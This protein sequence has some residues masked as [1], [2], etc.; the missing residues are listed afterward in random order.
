M[1]IPHNRK[2]QYAAQRACGSCETIGH[3][4]CGGKHRHG[5]H[6]RNT[7]E[8]G[9]VTLLYASLVEPQWAASARI[10]PR[11][12]RGEGDEGPAVSEKQDTARSS[13]WEP[14]WPVFRHL[15]T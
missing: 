10:D 14:G 6:K 15:D 3:A 11:P 12:P 4:Q 13:V 9:S 1:C 2:T 5:L 8:V 7:P